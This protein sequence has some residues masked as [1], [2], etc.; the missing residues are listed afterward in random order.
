MSSG[1]TFNK[2]FA[3][4][5]PADLVGVDMGVT[6]SRRGIS[7]SQLTY[8]EMLL[9]EKPPARFHH[10]MCAGADRVCHQTIRQM[11]RNAVIIG[12]P[13]NLPGTQL[14]LDCDFTRSPKPPLQRNQDIVLESNF[15]AAFPLS[16]EV[17]RSGTWATIRFARK[18]SLP[19]VI[20]YPN[21]GVVWEN[22]S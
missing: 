1:S 15:L 9:Q 12:H 20:C 8:F 16:T 13:S 2:E 19:L 4:I 10:G 5:T 14:D 11:I 21:G 18:K 22:G 7:P 3:N 6:G 17:R